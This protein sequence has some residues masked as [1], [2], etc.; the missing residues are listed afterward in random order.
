MW[1][2][3]HWPLLCL[4][5]I[6]SIVFL[7]EALPVTHSVAWFLVL[8][9]LASTLYA[10]ARDARPYDAP[11]GGWERV[12]RFGCAAFLPALGILGWTAMNG[13]LASLPARERRRDFVPISA[14][15]LPMTRKRRSEQ[16]PFGE[17]GLIGVVRHANDPERRLQAVLASRQLPGR[18]SVPILKFAL[19]DPIDDVRLLAYSLL[20]RMELDI[21]ARIKRLLDSLKESEEGSR[22]HLYFKLAHEYWELAYAGLAHGEV[23][24]H[25]LSQVRENAEHGLELD[26]GNSQLHLLL[27]R[28]HL[29]TQDLDSAS[30]HLQRAIECGFPQNAIAPYEAEL[31][32]AYRDFDRVRERLRATDPTRLMTRPLREVATSWL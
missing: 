13:V 1:N 15:P 14:P 16:L 32:F 11:V 17:G 7:A 3:L 2:R 25:L 5:E 30:F 9:L 31:A 22:G 28:L 12:W 18:E 4:L 6:T 29:K 10:F 27:G 23:M 26:P 20:D 8:H 24:G 19:K 21:N